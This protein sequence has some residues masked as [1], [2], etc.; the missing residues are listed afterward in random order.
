M[1]IVSLVLRDIAERDLVQLLLLSSPRRVDR[2]QNWPCHQ[3][4]HQTYH[5]RDLQVAEQ[6]EP[7]EGGVR[8]DMVV[9]ELREGPEP[10]EKAAWEFRGAFTV[11]SLSI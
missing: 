11:K 6:E 5:S 2:Q 9:G 8:K 7:I 4:S 1:S 3:R 10:I